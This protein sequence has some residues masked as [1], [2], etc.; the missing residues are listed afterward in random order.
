MK[1]HILILFSLSLIAASSL[2]QTKP[3]DILSEY[4][5]KSSPVLKQLNETLE[6]QGTAIAAALVSKGDTNG[7]VEVSNQLKEK[8]AGEA[9]LNP[10]ASVTTLFQQYDAAC[11]AALQPLQAASIAKIDSIL[12]TT[13]GKDLTIVT[14]LGKVRGEIEAGKHQTKPTMP[15]EWDYYTSPTSRKMGSLTLRPDGTFELHIPTAKTPKET[16]SWKPTKK[17]NVLTLKC[18]DE[19]WEV[20]W[21]N[22]TATIERPL[23]GVRHL[24]TP[25][26]DQP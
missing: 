22:D 13:A 12:K 6:T 10:H 16:G 26:S 18:R 25:T 17:A 15:V 7:A 21:T 2:A 24:K 14:E 5:Q 1:T 9:V 11:T 19:N 3:T 8:I 23:I 4:H 20:V